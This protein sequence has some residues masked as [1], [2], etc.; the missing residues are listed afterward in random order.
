M[1]IGVLP[2]M[3]RAKG[4]GCTCCQPVAV[5]RD[6]DHR[7]AHRME[8]LAHLVRG[9]HLDAVGVQQ[10]LVGV[11]VVHH[12]QA[13]IGAPRRARKSACRRGA[14]RPAP[15][16]RR[17]CWML[18]GCEGRHLARDAGGRAPGIEHLPLV[19]G[20]HDDGVAQGHGHAGEPEAGV[21]RA[22]EGSAQP[23]PNSA[24]T[25]AAEPDWRRKWRR[26]SGMAGVLGGR[27]P[28][29]SPRHRYRAILAQTPNAP[30]TGDTHERSHRMDPPPR[31]R[32]ANCSWR[33]PTR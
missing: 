15:P 12:E 10:L 16:G 26:S 2:W 17:R 6:L 24:T 33:A 4:E 1:R 29:S 14:C 31:R 11:F 8:R 28:P 7:D 22:A 20:R 27:Q 3:R 30:P 13:A 25:A 23:W 19:F 32:G 21:A 18:S 5:R 9:P